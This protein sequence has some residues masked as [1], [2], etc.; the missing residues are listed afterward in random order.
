MCYLRK[1]NK[2]KVINVHK[3]IINQPKTKISELLETLSTQ[4]DKVMP[5]DK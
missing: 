2:M 3:L 1:S 4:N 5:T